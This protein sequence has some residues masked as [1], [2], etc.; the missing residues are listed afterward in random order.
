MVDPSGVHYDEDGALFLS[1]CF[2]CR[3][4]LSRRKLPRFALANLN[5]IGAIPPELQSLTLVEELIVSRC[6]AKLCIVKLQDHNDDVDLPTVQRGM[7]G[8]I[9]VFPQHPENLPD[10]MPAPISDIISPICILF[11]G[12][13]VPT[14]QWLKEK[15]RPLVMRREVILNALQWLRAHNP[16]YQNVV[17]DM[18]RI[19]MLPE[20]D[21]LDYHIE[22]V[23]AS[24]ATR[25]LVSRYNSSGG[26]P[27]GPPPPD[28]SVQFESVLITDVDANAPSHQLKAAALRYAKR[29][30]SFVQIPRDPNPVN[31][32]FN[33]VTFPMLY[34]TL[35][36]YG[37]G[38]FEDSRREVLI[39]FEN[40]VKHMLALNDRRFQEHYSFMFVAFNV[41]QRRRLLLHKLAFE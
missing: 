7:K 2:P 9:I 36:P 23:E 21:V 5:V 41:I 6:R 16:L 18:S 40:H 27:T 13:S 38:G 32:F 24:T 35:F 30:G 20:N 11:C 26:C 31:E 19:S 12:S 28:A 1:L 4:A 34:P 8:H 33:P 37:I 15:A 25:T 17:I 3:S 39:G 29:G 10:V 22:Q 14:P